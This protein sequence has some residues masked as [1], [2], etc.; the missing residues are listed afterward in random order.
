M[1]KALTQVLEDNYW[2][3][4]FLFCALVAKYLA[5]FTE[6]DMAAP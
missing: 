3:Y 5:E 6:S 1:V 2:L 4:P